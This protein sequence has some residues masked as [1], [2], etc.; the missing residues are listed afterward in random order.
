MPRRDSD[1]LRCISA[2]PE[3]DPRGS[4]RK[5]CELMLCINIVFCLISFMRHDI[6]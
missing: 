6:L 5:E 1:A 4:I 3:H 2:T